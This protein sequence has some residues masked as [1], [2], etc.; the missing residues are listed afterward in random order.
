VPRARTGAHEPFYHA[1]P[2]GLDNYESRPF[3]GV[4]A[5]ENHPVQ[6]ALGALDLSR[7]VGR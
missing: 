3:Q 2:G 4:P 1:T 5:R 7:G 6:A